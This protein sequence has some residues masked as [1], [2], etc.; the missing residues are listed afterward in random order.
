LITGGVPR[1][2]TRGP[3]KGQPTWDRTDSKKCVVS[4]AECEAWERDKKAGKAFEVADGGKAGDALKRRMLHLS[5]ALRAMHALRD[6]VKLPET[7]G[8]HLY[9]ATRSMIAAHHA[10]CEEFTAIANSFAFNE[11]DAIRAVALFFPEPASPVAHMFGD[12]R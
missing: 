5:A 7:S 4:S 8:V 10:A 12:K 9:S 1:L 11:K 2:I 3:R 6:L